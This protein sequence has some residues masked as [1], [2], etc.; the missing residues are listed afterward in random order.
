MK[1][2]A[3]GLVAVFILMTTVTP[4]L[5][6]DFGGNLRVWYKVNEDQDYFFFDQL[7]LTLRAP[8]SEDNGFKG[9]IKF[10]KVDK[11]DHD[12]ADIRLVAAYYYQTNLW[13]KDE[14]DIGYFN[15][16]FYSD[17]YITL[18]NS[19][20]YNYAWPKQSLGVKYG[21]DWDK[22][23]T[24]MAV[25][26]AHNLKNDNGP[27]SGYDFAFRTVFKPID[28]LTL[29]LGYANDKINTV[30]NSKNQD[31]VVDAAFTKGPYGV[32]AEY[33]WQKPTVNGAK[34]DEKTG[35]YLEGTYQFNERLTG[36]V[37]TTISADDFTSDYYLLGAKFLLAKKTTLQAEFKQLDDAD[38]TWSFNVRLKVDF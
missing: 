36:Y 11:N 2:L 7:D 31:F 25:T 21:F 13:V 1:K 10:L 32:F 15:I 27:N 14:L 19:L 5:A 28:E 6:L 37:G 17:R 34:Q 3:I 29:G 26:N 20:S 30:T 24:T 35:G 22:F 4:A 12:S 23:Q 18:T 16:P 9:E 33:V 8:I 38:D